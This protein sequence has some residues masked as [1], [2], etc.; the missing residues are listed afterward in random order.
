MRV[1]ILTGL[2]GCGKS[3]V[4]TQW[5]PNYTRINQDELGDRQA[6]IES[7]RNALERNFDV[8]VDRT[9]VTRDQRKHWIDLALGYGAESLTSIFL[10]VPEEECIARIDLRKD[11]PTIKEDMP[12]EKKKSIVYSFNRTLQIPSLTEGFKTIIIHSNF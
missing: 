10:D 5:F 1:I 12:L 9:N 3:T 6:C 7:M 2:P 4:A 11:H 8:I